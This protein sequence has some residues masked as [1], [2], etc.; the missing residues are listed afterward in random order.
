M[1]FKW[2]IKEN[3][4]CWYELSWQKEEPA[5]L[6]RVHQ[7]F[8]KSTRMFPPESPIIRHYMEAFK[9]SN[10][11]DSLNGNFGFNNTLFEGT[12]NYQGKKDEFVEFLI[13]LPIIKVKTHEVCD[14]CHGSGKDT[15]IEEDERDCIHCEGTGTK[16]DYLWQRAYAVSA[17]F[18]I[19]FKIARYPEKETSSS[20]PQLIIVETVTDREMHG[21]SLGGE[22]SI[23]LRNWLASLGDASLPEVTQA[24]KTAYGH[25]FSG[26]RH[27]NDYYF[28][29]YARSN[30]GFV[31]DCPGDACGLHPSGWH[32]PE[33][34]GYEF[35]CHNVDSPAQQITLLAGLAAL[36]DRARKEINA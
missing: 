3:I 16:Y 5:I 33:G 28:K 13:K 6:L 17:S 9:F 25:M 31:A 11:S 10:F 22:I 24:T 32:K 19:F 15:I 29:S 23:P 34:E 2:L 18:T 8:I 26:L 21:G 20:L 4:P 35:S 14:Y 30:G 1:D 7:D 27:F 12:F 36:H